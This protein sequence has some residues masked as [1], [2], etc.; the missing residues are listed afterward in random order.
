MTH[1]SHAHGHVRRDWTTYL[2][3]ILA[4]TSAFSQIRWKMSSN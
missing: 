2:N 3:N 4:E 1:Q